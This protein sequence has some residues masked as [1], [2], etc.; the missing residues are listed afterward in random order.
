MNINV[1]GK[2]IRRSTNTNSFG[3][4]GF[5]F[6]EDHPAQDFSGCRVF[7]FASSTDFERGQDVTIPFIAGINGRPWVPAFELPKL[8]YMIPAEDRAKFIGL[9]NL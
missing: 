4:R 1:A 3:L 7:E 6:I 5:W 2:I 8:R 9:F